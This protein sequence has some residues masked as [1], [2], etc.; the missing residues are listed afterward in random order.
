MKH[1]NRSSLTQAQRE[2]LKRTLEA[3]R[4]ELQHALRQHE[5]LEDAL[6]AGSSEREPGDPADRAETAT[7][8]HERIS[9]A[10]RDLELLEEV[11]A[12]LGRFAEGTYGV[13]ETSGRPIPFERLRAVP[14]TRFEVDEGERI[15]HAVRH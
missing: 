4:A 1:E 10:D 14:W 15:E 12:A 8:E 7:E 11:D 6:E 9:L 13:S 2:E 3:K 5:V